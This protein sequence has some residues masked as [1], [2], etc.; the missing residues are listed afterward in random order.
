MENM[1]ELRSLAVM[2]NPFSEQKEYMIELNELVKKFTHIKEL[3]YIGSHED[4]NE[5]EKF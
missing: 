1:A 3:K 5:L 4:E 2:M